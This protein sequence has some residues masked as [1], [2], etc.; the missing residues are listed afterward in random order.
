MEVQIEN[1]RKKRAEPVKCFRSLNINPQNQA[2]FSNTV[3][4]STHFDPIILNLDD[5]KIKRH[6]LRDR[7]CR[8]VSLQIFNKIID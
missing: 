3:F 8:V 7:K 5:A 2:F 6:H 4:P 1:A